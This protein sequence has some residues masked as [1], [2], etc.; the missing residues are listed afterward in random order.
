MCLTYED[1]LVYIKPMP[2]TKDGV[3]LLPHEVHLLK[4]TLDKLEGEQGELSR[5]MGLAMSE[6]S[7]TW[8]DNAP[9][10]VVRDA[11]NVLFER[12]KPYI[13]LLGSYALADYPEPGMLRL[14]SKITVAMDGDPFELI[15]VGHAGLYEDHI[16]DI[17]EDEIDINSA[18]PD[19]VIFMSPGAPLA[20][21][22][23]ASDG[24]SHV[25]Y[26]V[27]NSTMQAVIHGIDNGFILKKPRQLEE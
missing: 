25:E 6:S 26:E 16:F 12:A 27:G 19:E 1:K 8:H 11:A 15:L 2:E 17:V 22:L 10:D 4:R 21:A 24:K 20:R 7:E 18:N 14:G 13:R 23:L 9:A 5:L 3:P